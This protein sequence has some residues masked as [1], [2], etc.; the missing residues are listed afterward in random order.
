VNTTD[1]VRYMDIQ[2]EINLSIKSNFEEQGIQMPF[3]TQN[4]HVRI[5]ESGDTGSVDAAAGR[6]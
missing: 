1:Y 4:M 6:F 2:Q 3:P 5:Q